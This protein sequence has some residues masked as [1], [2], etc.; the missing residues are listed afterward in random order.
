M[1]A[2]T[3]PEPGQLV[4]VRLRRYV[5]TEVLRSALPPALDPKGIE[6]ATHLVTLSSLE[7]DALGEELQVIWE[8]EPG[9]RA[10]EEGGVAD[11]GWV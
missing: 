2:G 6:P 3:I 11:A 5:V 4:D 8:L 7:D 9:A 10:F 1:L